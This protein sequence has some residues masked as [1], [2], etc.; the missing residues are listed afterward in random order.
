M[1]DDHNSSH[2]PEYFGPKTSNILEN[3]IL[4]FSLYA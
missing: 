2:L 4:N 3:K 1:T